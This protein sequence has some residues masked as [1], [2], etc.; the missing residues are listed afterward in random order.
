[1]IILEGQLS[2]TN[3]VEIKDGTTALFVPREGHFS[4]EAIAFLGSN[5]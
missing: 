5:G 3:V 4:A 1:M 2:S